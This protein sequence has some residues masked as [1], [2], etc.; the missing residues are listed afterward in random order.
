M[1]LEDA[2]DLTAELDLLKHQMNDM[3]KQLNQLLVRK[4]ANSGPSVA[5]EAEAGH[6]AA[7][8][9]YY[10]GH[11]QNNSSRYRWEPQERNVRHLIDTDGEKA[12]KILAALGHKQRVD[13]LRALLGKPQT[14]AELVELLN[15]GTTGQLYHHIKALV[16]ADLLQQE[17]RGGK[18]SIAQHRSLPM[19]VLLAAVTD[20][21]DTSDYIDMTEVRGNAGAYLGTA[22]GKYDS[23]LLLWAVLDN[24]VLE[25]KAGCCSEVHVYIHDNA[26]VTVAD[27][28]RGIPT[29]ALA[30]TGKSVV[31][32]VMTD[33]EWLAAREASFVAPGGE[34]GI[35]IAV[36]NALSLQLHVEVRREGTI[37]VQS[38]KHGIPQT[39][40]L[41]VGVTNETGTSVTIRPDPELF[42]AEFDAAIIGRHIS[43]LAEAYPG[44]SISLHT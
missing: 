8:A 23:H 34:K 39:E 42:T 31:Q 30:G 3:Q 5:P 44:L 41:P 17:E 10:S 27:N 32:T 19:L 4:T 38:Y 22:Q 25:H 26:A 28:G 29:K 20:L 43:E 15:M 18:Y 33:L 24:S 1:F 12:A 36:V 7:G 21:L 13:I 37:H 11:F 40:L 35:S 14:G 2:R 9:I 6:T 16:G